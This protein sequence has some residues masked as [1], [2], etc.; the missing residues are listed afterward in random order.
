ML[1][2]DDKLDFTNTLYPTG[3]VCP[4]IQAA[5]IFFKKGIAMK[6]E[7][8][9][10]YRI[11]RTLEWLDHCIALAIMNHGAALV[12]VSVWENQARLRQQLDAHFCRN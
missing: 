1:Y 3:A 11:A 9:E 4:P 8:V 12:P 2:S 10:P 7:H 5:P 6:P